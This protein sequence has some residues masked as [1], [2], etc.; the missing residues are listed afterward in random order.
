MNRS[1]AVNY[2]LIRH[3]GDKGSNTQIANIVLPESSR[4]D[5]R[6]RQCIYVLEGLDEAFRFVGRN[7]RSGRH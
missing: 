2:R 7:Q 3:L 4:I 5:I 1:F 6:I